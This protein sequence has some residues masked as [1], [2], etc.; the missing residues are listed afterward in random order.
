MGDTIRK[1]MASANTSKQWVGTKADELTRLV[2][3]LSVHPSTENLLTVQG[4]LK[5]VKDC[6]ARGEEKFR[7]AIELEEDEERV[8]EYQARA[9]EMARVV[10]DAET[11]VMTARSATQAAL[12]APAPAAPAA[13]AAGGAAGGHRVAEVVRPSKLTED[14]TPEDVTQWKDEFGT[15][16]RLAGVESWQLHKDKQNFFF[17]CLDK[18]LK[19]QVKHHGLYNEGRPILKAD[20]PLDD[21]LEEIIDAIFLA[22]CPTFARR[23]DYFTIVQGEEEPP[24]F[25]ARLVD[26]SHE[27][28]VATME[29]DDIMVHRAFDGIRDEGLRREWRRLDNPKWDDLI[30]AMNKYMTSKRDEKAAKAARG[31]ARAARTQERGGD[32]RARPRS[33]NQG[34]PHDW[35]HGGPRGMEGPLPEVRRKGPHHLQML[36]EESRCLVH[37]V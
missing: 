3:V 9:D 30:K 13:P 22:K 27:A 16:Y 17:G 11:T 6:A 1:A 21:S 32:N 37:G 19:Q 33:Q 15:Y 34:T 18:S 24:Q 8:K 7:T 28:S 10:L 35:R 20:P 12:R 26:R 31:A 2:G 25:M 4:K 5:E 29:Y 14:A 23:L 36:Q